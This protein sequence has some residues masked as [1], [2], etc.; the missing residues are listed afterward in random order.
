MTVKR[1]Q[2]LS[3]RLQQ[4]DFALWETSLYLDTHPECAQALEYYKKLLA[5]RNEARKQY[6]AQ[7]GPLTHCDITGNRWSWVDD[8]WPWQ[9]EV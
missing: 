5:M 3:K 9:N 4:L 6:V 2:N 7:N 1:N 8:P